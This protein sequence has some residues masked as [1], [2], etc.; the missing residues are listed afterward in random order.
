[1]SVQAGIWNL[2]GQP[3]DHTLLARISSETAALAPDGESTY[4]EGAVGMLY[5][6][7]H[8]TSE[9]WMEIQ[10]HVAPD[11]HI[12]TW[13]GR[14]DNRDKLIADVRSEL[15]NDLTDVAIVSAA[16]MRW[17]LDCFAH[18]I[19]DWALAIWN[20]YE[21]EVILA[22]DWAGIRHLYYYPT[23]RRIVWCT[24]L[25]PLFACGDQFT[26]CPEYIAS[27][28]ASRP[29]ASLTPYRELRAIPPGSFVRI[30]DHRMRVDFYWT[31]NPKSR[32]RY[33]N[34]KEYEEQFRHLFRQAVRRRLRSPLPILAEL[35]GGFDSS[36]IVCMADDI[37]AN[38]GA[39]APALDTFSYIS[40]DA[41]R[42]KGL[43][44]VGFMI[45]YT[46][47]PSAQTH[48]FPS[49]E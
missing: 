26:L 14:L 13:D 42:V 31:F 43:G 8:T 20:P 33:R 47:I 16:Y 25:A 48:C 10:P 27:S 37:I 1:M 24:H 23:A 21:R 46:L 49:R 2:D 29:S 39:E 38:E 30:A 41:G 5:R 3:I 32:T 18:L 9:S 36:S 7:L 17:R 28:L 45:S 6:P 19:G 34:D 40:N 44:V 35:S 22:R 11:G 15:R 12:M 4:L